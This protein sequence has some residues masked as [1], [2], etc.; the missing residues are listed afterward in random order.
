MKRSIS[1]RAVGALGVAA[2]LLLTGAC[3]SG[4]D[5]EKKDDEKA[6]TTTTAA[7][8]EEI[9][10]EE[11]TAALDDF[12]AAL[13]AAGNDLCK[14][15]E[16]QAVVP[17]AS[18]ANELQMEATIAAYAGMLRAFATVVEDDPDAAATFRST[19]DE[20][21]KGAEAA[22]YP[23]DYLTPADAQMPEVLSTP[24]YIAASQVISDRFAQQCQGAGAG[25]DGAATGGTD[26][27]GAEAPTTTVAP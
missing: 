6:E 5:D 24:E 13:A 20:L 21:V 1:A 11:F 27:S 4:S 16:A 9:P 23:K 17:K 12:S 8:A 10:D 15:S 3:S 14:M 18:P 26:G 25:T 2:V 19:A 7:Q 22:G